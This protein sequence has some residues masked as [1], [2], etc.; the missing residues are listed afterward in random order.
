MPNIEDILNLKKGE[1]KIIKVEDINDT[2]R[3]KEIEEELT[4]I[5]EEMDIKMPQILFISKYESV[6]N[7]DERDLNSFGWYRRKSNYLEEKIISRSGIV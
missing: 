5:C 7:L 1:I 6:E 2:A 3:I 4:L